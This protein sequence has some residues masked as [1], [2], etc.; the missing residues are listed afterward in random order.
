MTENTT[1]AAID[2]ALA[3]GEA[4]ADDPMLREL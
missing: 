3:A 4:T 1:L 2:E